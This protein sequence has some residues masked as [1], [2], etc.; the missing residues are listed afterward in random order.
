[1]ER[2]LKDLNTCFAVLQ[3]ETMETGALALIAPHAEA[4]LALKRKMVGEIRTTLLELLPK[5][6]CEF[7]ITSSK[8]LTFIAP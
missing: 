7:L 4:Q 5:D 2:E 6:S 3:M 8:E 1:M